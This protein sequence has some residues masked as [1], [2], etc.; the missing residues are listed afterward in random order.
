M[1]KHTPWPWKVGHQDIPTN[2][3][4]VHI[5][6][7][8]DHKGVIG[9]AYACCADNLEANARLIAA[10]PELLAACKALHTHPSMENKQDIDAEHFIIDKQALQNI[11]QAINKAEGKD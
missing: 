9:M 6:A 8:G 4:G 10:A 7:T 11:K 1:E 5:M 2:W 3:Q